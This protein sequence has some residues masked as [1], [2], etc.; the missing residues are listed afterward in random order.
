MNG[1][2]FRRILACAIFWISTAMAAA[3]ERLTVLLVQDSDFVPFMYSDNEG[4]A[5]IYTDIL[6]A[7]AARLPDYDISITASA[8]QRAKFLVETGRAHGLIGSYYTPSQRPWIHRYSVPFIT[9]QITV[10]CREG[11]NAANWVYPDDYAGLRFT[12]NAGFATPGDAFLKMVAERKID[13]IEEQT[14]EQNLRLLELG[15]ADCYVQDEVT[16]NNVLSEQA[17]EKIRPVARIRAE[18]VHVGYSQ[19]WTGITSGQ[20][21]EDMDAVLEAMRADG[22]I[23]AIISRATGGS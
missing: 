7:A 19:H 20:F 5:G 23:Q 15:R 18:T 1:T 17:F 8:W 12:N 2:R 10:F 6:R 21:I 16:V 3:E 4:A 11:I 22:T 13:L 9:D 14:T